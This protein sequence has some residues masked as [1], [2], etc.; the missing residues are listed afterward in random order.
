MI[1]IILQIN[2]KCDKDNNDQNF[3]YIYD[4]SNNNY[5]YLS[6]KTYFYINYTHFISFNNITVEARPKLDNLVMTNIGSIALQ[7][8]FIMYGLSSSY[9][10]FASKDEEY[11]A[12]KQIQNLN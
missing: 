9:L 4:L 5:I 7:N 3:I 6:N 11:S 12:Y 1:F 2:V 8:E 10:L